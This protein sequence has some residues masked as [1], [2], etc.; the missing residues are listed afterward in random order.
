M[1]KN[2]QT[3]L[4]LSQAPDVI[5]S[6][7]TVG[8]SGVE[9]ITLTRD[10]R[11]QEYLFSLIDG[12][13]NSDAQ[14]EQLAVDAAL[15]IERMQWYTQAA[16]L[17][18]ELRRHIEHGREGDPFLI[19]PNA[20]QRELLDELVRLADEAVP[21]FDPSRPIYHLTGG[22][23]LDVAA[24]LA[25]G[26][27]TLCRDAGAAM[28][29]PGCTEGYY[30]QGIG[31]WNLYLQLPEGLTLDAWVR[32]LAQRWNNAFADEMMGVEISCGDERVVR[33]FLHERLV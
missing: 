9:L 8:M 33:D 10:G 29:R 19:L 4:P 14:L 15:L 7:R 22:N 5:W 13:M 3:P 25:T 21:P 16:A 30:D 24:D 11:D 26:F 12:S 20:T 2:V 17:L 23:N 18:A 1:R 6:H 31:A 28:V 32:A 27:P